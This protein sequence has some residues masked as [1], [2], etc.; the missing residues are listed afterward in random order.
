MD[1]M[2]GKQNRRE[3]LQNM[4]IIGAVILG[5]G[6]MVRAFWLYLFPP[7]KEKKYHRYLVCKDGD[8]KIGEAREITLGKTPVYVVHLKE[9]YKVYSGI[10]T[11]LGCIIHW[12]P[13]KNRFYCPCHKGIFDPYGKVVSGPPPRPMDEYKVEKDGKLVFMYVEDKMKGPWT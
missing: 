10:C 3:F 7:K 12:E 6:A 9:G 5:I 11:H 8:L 1:D 4:G 2:K 13:E